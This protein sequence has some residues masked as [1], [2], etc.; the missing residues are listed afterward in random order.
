MAEHILDSFIAAEKRRHK[1]ELKELLSILTSDLSS[2]DDDTYEPSRAL[3]DRLLN[4]SKTGNRLIA[5]L[6][7]KGEING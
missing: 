5:L 4:I 1:R 2:I 6:Q 7:L 3:E